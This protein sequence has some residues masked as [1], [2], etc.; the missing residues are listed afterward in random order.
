MLRLLPSPAL[1]LIGLASLLLLGGLSSCRQ[2]ESP[3]VAAQRTQTLLLGNG[4]EPAD[5]DPHTVTAFTDMNIMVALFE[6]LTVLDEASSA[7]LPGVAESWRVSPDG[8]TWTF[9][10]RANAR[11]SDGTPVTAGD[12]VY[13]FRRILAP[14]LAAEYAYMLW[15]LRHAQDYNEGRQTDPQEIGARAADPRTLVLTLA[16]PCPWLLTLVSNQAWFPVPRATIARFGGSDERGTRWTRPENFVGNGP[17]RLREW[18]PHARLVVEQNPHYWDLAHCRIRRVVFFPNE[19]LATDERN[20]RTGQLH[21]TYDL[22]PE[23]IAAYR[24]S[25]PANLRIDPFYETFF[26]RF[27]TSRPPLDRPAVRLA[28]TQAIDRAALCRSVLRDSRLPAFAYTPPGAAGYQS[29]ARIVED[30]EHARRLLAEAGFPGGQG[31][32]TLEVELKSD[33]IHRAVMEAI[34]QMWL[35]ELGVRVTLSPLEQKTWLAHQQAMSFQIS[36]GRWIGDFLD[37][38][39]FLELFLS[40]SGKNQTGWKDAEYDRLISTAARTLDVQPRQ[41]LQRQAEARLLAAAPIAPIFYGARVYLLHA[42]VGQWPPALLGLR[43]Y[44]YVTLASPP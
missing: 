3:V 31:F 10:L 28:L 7:P 26:L 37:A 18:T 35:R 9:K 13:S 1:A 43:R 38:N 4:A 42:T 5:L 11:W 44:Q 25:A 20:F 34:Q 16:E 6:G 8:L 33:D 23:K 36:S 21:A 29:R 2:A 40:G 17:F 24:Q 12:F 15:P 39:T 32:P 22:P 27:N 30:R 41:E 14:K 19:N